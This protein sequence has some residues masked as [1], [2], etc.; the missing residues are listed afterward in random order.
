[1]P[2]IRD[3]GTR[4]RDMILEHEGPFARG[5]YKARRLRVPERRPA[6]GDLLRSRR[7]TTI[8]TRSERKSSAAFQA[9]C[10]FR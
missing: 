8:R 3:C 6:E 4:T 7:A 1:M 2:R 5:A 9:V 10:P